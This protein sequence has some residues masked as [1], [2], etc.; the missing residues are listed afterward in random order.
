MCEA[1]SGGWAGC[2][3]LFFEEVSCRFS[4]CSSSAAAAGWRVVVTAGVGGV[5][6]RVASIQCGIFPI[7]SGAV[8]SPSVGGHGSVISLLVLAVVA[9]ITVPCWHAPSAHG[10]SSIGAAKEHL[11][12][13]EADS[14]VY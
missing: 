9:A 3:G 8:S 12:F 5:E 2:L 13:E 4:S 14:L 10:S 6:G 7:D 1:G 11:S